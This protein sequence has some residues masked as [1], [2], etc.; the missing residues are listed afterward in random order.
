MMLFLAAAWLGGI[1]ALNEVRITQRWHTV[2]RKATRQKNNWHQC[3][4]L[5]RAAV[6]SLAFS[7]NF[8]SPESGTGRRRS[9][10]VLPNTPMLE[11][12]SWRKRLG[13]E[14][15]RY[16]CDPAHSRQILAVLALCYFR[17]PIPS[18]AVHPCAHW[19]RC[20]RPSVPTSASLAA[21][22]TA[23]P[24]PVP[25]R[26]SGSPRGAACRRC[27][28]A[29]ARGCDRGWSLL[30]GK[31]QSRW[32]CTLALDRYDRVV[33]C[34]PVGNEQDLLYDVP[35]F[36]AETGGVPS[37]TNGHAALT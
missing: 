18:G 10:R 25:R 19:R 24:S 31:W 28:P 3:Q 23:C 14:L 34:A 7:G 11:G 33:V 6:R 4:L 5:A 1:A 30:L 36:H 21:P 9:G 8:N 32:R 26:R 22:G 16:V 27:G 35:A 37:A 29:I 2:K 12:R 15:R 13:V 20:S 17:L